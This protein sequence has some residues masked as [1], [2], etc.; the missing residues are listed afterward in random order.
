MNARINLN[1]PRTLQGENLIGDINID[2]ILNEYGE[3]IIEF[4]NQSQIEVHI[5]DIRQLMNAVEAGELDLKNLIRKG[6]A[7]KPKF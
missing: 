5:D 6:Q 1:K 2:W 7:I 4:N 3:M